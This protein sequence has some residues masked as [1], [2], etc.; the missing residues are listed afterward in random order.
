MPLDWIA[1]LKHHLSK[2]LSSLNII[3]NNSL[4]RAVLYNT[5]KTASKRGIQSHITKLN[6]TVIQALKGVVEAQAAF[7]DRLVSILGVQSI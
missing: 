3:E 2:I 5:D 7:R 1:S 6:T 4:Q